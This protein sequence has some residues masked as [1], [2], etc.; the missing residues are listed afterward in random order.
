MAPYLS[1]V[2][3][4]KIP[5]SYELRQRLRRAVLW[6]CLLASPFFLGLI[7]GWV[8][9][10]R[11]NLTP[12]LPRGFYITSNS[13]SANLVEFCPQGAAASI[14]L[15][16]QYR[17]AG[18]CPDGGAPLL[19][20]AVAFPGDQ[21]EVSADGIR[22]NG[23][24]LPNSAGRFRDH[25]QRPLD[26]WPYGTYRVDQEP[27]GSSPRSTATV[28]TA[29][30]TAPFQ[31]P[32]FGTISA[33]CGRSLRKLLSSR[34]T[35][36]VVAATTA[37]VAWSGHLAAI[38]LSLVAPVLV[39]YTKSRTHAYILDVL[40]L[41]IGQLAAHPRSTRFLWTP[42]DAAHWIVPV[43]RCCGALGVALGFAI[44][45]RAS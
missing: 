4:L 35:L 11:L 41:R 13:P 19:K 2:L 16:R 43:S 18:A 26:P 3:K 27:C 1:N 21:V 33:H 5:G 24:L 12:S 32:R 8:F 34:I 29:A 36:P 9:G 38:P 39:P 42:G 15:N 6:A 25:L 20:P 37:A 28:S 17:T 40:L 10:V 22:V 45:A 30:I 23:Q 31:S 14:S 44:H 7:A